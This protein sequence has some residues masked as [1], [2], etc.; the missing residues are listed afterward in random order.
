MVK[1]IIYRLSLD[2]PCLLNTLINSSTWSLI[3]L[4]EKALPVPLQTATCTFLH[5]DE[6]S[7]GFSAKTAF[8]TTKSSSTLNL[9][10]GFFPKFM[11]FKISLPW[12]TLTYLYVMAAVTSTSTVQ[13][14]DNQQTFFTKNAITL[15]Y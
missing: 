14:I 9:S 11:I 2:W 15:F 10:L 7:K 5:F 12:T 13:L 1:I 3:V 6:S 4:S 8:K